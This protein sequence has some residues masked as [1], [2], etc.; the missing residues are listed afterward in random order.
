MTHTKEENEQIIVENS[1]EDN[2]NEVDMEA[3][4][5]HSNHK[6]ASNREEEIS[7]DDSEGSKEGVDFEGGFSDDSKF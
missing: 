2:I 7:R 6:A 3:D 1:E 4:Y 5:S